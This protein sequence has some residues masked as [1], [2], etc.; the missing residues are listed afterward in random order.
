M[1]KYTLT[2]IFAAVFGS[3]AFAQSFT[4]GIHGGIVASQIDGDK[5][6]G[7]RKFSPYGGLFLRHPLG[8]GKWNAQMELNYAGRGAGSNDGSVRTAMGYAEIPLLAA[9]NIFHFPLQIRAGAAVAYKIF[10]NTTT[11]DITQKSNDYG[12]WDFPVLVSIDYTITERIAIDA[13]FSYSALGMGKGFYNNALNVG[14][15]YYIVKVND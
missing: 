1:N 6:S 9:C 10:E 14:L 2:L 4:G 12:T 8:S 5:M 13:R 7:Y 11:F 3:A 15:R